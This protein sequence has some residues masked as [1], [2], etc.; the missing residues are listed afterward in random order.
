MSIKRT[1]DVFLQAISLSLG[2]YVG[3]FLAFTIERVYETREFSSILS[4][5]IVVYE[6]YDYS[7]INNFMTECFDMANLVLV[8]S[9]IG[10]SAL[11]LFLFLL[12]YTKPYITKE[13]FP[14]AI[15]VILDVIIWFFVPLMVI[16]TSIQNPKIVYLPE[17]WDINTGIPPNDLSALSYNIAQLDNFRLFSRVFLSAT[18]TMTA[19]TSFLALGLSL[20]KAIKSKETKWGIVWIVSLIFAFSI[21]YFLDKYIFSFATMPMVYGDGFEAYG[22]GIFGQLRVGIPPVFLSVHNLLVQ[23]LQI[24]LGA[25]FIWCGLY[26]MR[27]DIERLIAKIK[28]YMRKDEPSRCY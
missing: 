26:L 13:N 5:Y 27:K 25:H 9:I 14:F 1:N 7:F 17:D 6:L 15:L 21:I 19:I 23:I 8:S 4:S 10:I 22:A 16:V 24:L 3:M 28:R 12:Q 11:L 18:K 2:T 20:S